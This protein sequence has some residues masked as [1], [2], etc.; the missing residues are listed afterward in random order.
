MTTQPFAD[1]DPEDPAEILRA[2]RPAFHE[3]FLSDYRDAVEQ[4]REPGNY[5]ELRKFLHFWRLYAF[6]SAQPGFDERMAAARESARTGDW[7]EWVPLEDVIAARQP[8]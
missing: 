8:H 7:G 2:L 5:R 6:A 4:A 3:R 1:P